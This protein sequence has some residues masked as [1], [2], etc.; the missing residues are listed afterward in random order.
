MLILF[1]FFQE[2]QSPR[3]FV[4]EAEFRENL[5]AQVALSKKTL[6]TLRQFGVTADRAL[7]L[8]FFFC[9]DTE[10]KAMQ[11]THALSQRGYAV[12]YGPSASD[13]NVVVVSGW[14]DPIP[15]TEDVL[16]Q[17]AEAMCRVGYQF[18]CLFDGW[19]TSPD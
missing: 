8:E 3:R 19:G 5:S 1:I 11:L 7:K 6:A 15:M 12:S 14:T 13:S 10:F 17:W 9:T 2:K 4:T 16:V 18:D